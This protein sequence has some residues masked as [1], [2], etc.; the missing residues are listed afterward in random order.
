MNNLQKTHL[1]IQNR[2]HDQSHV[3]DMT[4]G[5]GH[6]TYFLAQHCKQVTA[7]DIQQIAIESTKKRCEAFGNVRY[8][9]S[10]HSKLD[11]ESLKPIH[12][13]IYNLGYLPK[14]D[15]D[16][17][18]KKESTIQSL[19]SLKK[20]DLEF[21]VITCYPR[22]E[23]GLEEAEAVLAW[24]LNNAD[25]YETMTYEKPLTPITYCIVF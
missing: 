16:L 3:I 5:N 15:K 20:Y 8:I 19:E 18:T 14:G 10:D 1:W 6:D 21:L 9:H 24:I 7:V 23:G 22:H 25:S 12:G 4:C 11:L 13:A 17:I 2:L